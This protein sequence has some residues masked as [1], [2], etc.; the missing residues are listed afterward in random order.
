MNVMC[1]DGRFEVIQ[2][3]YDDLLEST[4]IEMAD[5][6]MKVIKDILFRCWQMDWLYKYEPAKRVIEWHPYPRRKPTDEYGYYLVTIADRE[7]HEA[8]WSDGFYWDDG[9]LC[10]CRIEDVTAWAE[11]PGPYEEAK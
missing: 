3:A 7:V 8:I 5:D 1:G 10:E 11:M 9:D 4:N 6:E 2:K